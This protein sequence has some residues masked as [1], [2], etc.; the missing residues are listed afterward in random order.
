MVIDP[1]QIIW[2][3]DQYPNIVFGDEGLAY[4][5]VSEEDGYRTTGTLD[6][7]QDDAIAEAELVDLPKSKITFIRDKGSGKWMNRP[8]YLKVLKLL[9]TG[10]YKYFFM[11]D[12][13]RA[14]RRV[15]HQEHLF[16]LCSQIGVIVIPIGDKRDVKDV[17]KRI[18]IGV[19]NQFRLEADAKSAGIT[20]MSKIKQGR[21]MCRPPIG[22]AVERKMQN[23]KLVPMGWIHTPAMKVVE[24][25]FS[26]VLHTRRR[27]DVEIEHLSNKHILDKQAIFKILRNPMYAGKGRDSRIK[28][29]LYDLNSKR[30]DD[31]TKL[32]VV[33]IISFDDWTKVQKKIN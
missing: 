5:R 28:E 6:N 17:M 2:K 33:P 22:Y 16:E 11:K 1:L 27:I 32:Y 31:Q 29:D 30:N 9:C 19:M 25:I 3:P 10:R 26:S 21:P 18:F 24:D 15:Y 7:Q 12:M 8:P 14:S 20:S 13:S 4:L 23:D